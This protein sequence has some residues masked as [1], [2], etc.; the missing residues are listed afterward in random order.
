MSTLIDLVY[1]TQS[2]TYNQD[3]EDLDSAIKE[4]KRLPNNLLPKVVVHSEGNWNHEFK[5]CTNTGRVGCWYVAK[6]GSGCK[7]GG[8]GDL[9]HFKKIY[10]SL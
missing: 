9:A 5:I 10:P 1:T 6:E 7:S 3:F 4:L 2:S 8:F